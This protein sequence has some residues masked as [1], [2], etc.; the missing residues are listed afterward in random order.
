MVVLAIPKLAAGDAL[1]VVAELKLLAAV[2]EAVPIHDRLP[3][4]I[5]VAY[6][7]APPR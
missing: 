6:R 1:A 4:R 3:H 2:V 5:E 7:L